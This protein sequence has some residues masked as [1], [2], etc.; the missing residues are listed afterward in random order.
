MIVADA[1][2]VVEWLMGGKRGRAV[3]RILEGEDIVVP[4]HL[5]VEVAQVSR[6][7]TFDSVITPVRGRAMLEVLSEAPF[8]RFPSPRSFPGSGTSDGTSQHTTQLT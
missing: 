4:A 2:A 3:G 7:L 6:R 5:D 1:S 8:R